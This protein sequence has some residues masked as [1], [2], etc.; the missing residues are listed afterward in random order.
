M[1]EDAQEQVEDTEIE[2]SEVE[3]EEVEEVLESSES[4]A[5]KE[6]EPKKED[7]VQKRIDEL[8]RLRRE[9]E[10]DRDYWRELATKKE[11]EPVK[12]EP[13]EVKTLEDFD[14]D[15]KAYQSYI[16]QAAQNHAVEAAKRALEEDRTSTET[17][18]RQKAFEAKESKYAETVEDYIEATRDPSL[19]LT[20]DM[21]D[22][23]ATSE[24][25]P[26]LLYYLAK[27]PLIADSISRLPVTIAAREMGKIEARLAKESQPSKA[28]P[29]APKIDGVNAG[30]KVNPD[31]PA[32][33]KLPMDQ[34]LKARNKQIAKR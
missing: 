13:L 16:F 30:H 4:S 32:S 23:A 27:N 11:P 15:E 3:T 1:S 33:D 25:G 8:T 31:N 20:K 21:V 19:A 17:K 26:A 9:T 12:V 28:P 18:T 24:D 10:R 29:P 34:W 7:G 14:Y 2:A 5:E 22:I 6:P